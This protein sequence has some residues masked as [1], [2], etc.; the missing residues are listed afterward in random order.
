MTKPRFTPDLTRYEANTAKGLC[1]YCNNALDQNNRSI[2]INGLQHKMHE[3]CW[4]AILV[5]ERMLPSKQIMLGLT[6]S[7]FISFEEPNTEEYIIERYFRNR[8]RQA[9]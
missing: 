1:A 3:E 5:K 4:K 7:A 9:P 8:D 2:V 6:S